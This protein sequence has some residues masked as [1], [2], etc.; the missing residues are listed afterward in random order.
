MTACDAISVVLPTHNGGDYLDQAIES[1]VAQTFPHWELIVV[2]DASTDDTAS[3][4]G[5]WAD[6]DRRIRPIHLETNRRLPGALNEGFRH[7]TADLLTWTSDDNWYAPQ[8]FAR[9]ADLLKHQPD[10]D[11]VYA[12]VTKVDAAGRTIGQSPPGPPEDLAVTNCVGACFLYRRKVAEALGGYSEDLYLA[13]DYDFWLRASTQ[14]RLQP[15][16]ELLY[17]YRI[18]SESL[19]EKHTRAISLATQEAVERWLRG[20][21]GPTGSQRGRALES[22]GLRAMIRGDVPTG[23]KYLLRATWHLRRPPLFRECR[24]YAVD[25]LLGRRVGDFLRRTCLARYRSKSQCSEQ[26]FQRNVSGI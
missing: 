26:P 24:S 6:R 8:A 19:T 15:L 5:A 11:F 16:D 20:P 7:A 10:V 13:E 2:N 9:M 25:F 3:R 23:R 14:F 12:G 21:G 4:I 1:I 17:F 18:H 22:L